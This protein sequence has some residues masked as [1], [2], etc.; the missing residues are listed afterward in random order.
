M[1]PIESS[2]V[3][4]IGRLAVLGRRLTAHLSAS[5]VLLF[6]AMTMAFPLTGCTTVSGT[7]RTQFNFM[8]REQELSLGAGAYQEELA[9]A[10]LV[11]SGPQFDMVKRVTK[12]VSAAAEKLHPDATKGFTWEFR[13][14]D[15]PDTINAWAL[16]GGKMAVYT[17]L[18]KAAKNEDQLAAV[19][20]HECSHAIGRHGGERM[21]QQTAAQAIM[22]GVGVGLSFSEMSPTAQQATMA[23]FGA[24]SEYGVLLPFSRHQ[25]SEADELGLFIAA[26]A[27]YDP[28]EAVELWKNMG[29]IGGNKPPE[30]ASTHPSDETR[31][32]RLAELM[33]RAM[34][35]WKASKKKSKK[36]S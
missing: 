4:R 1:L 16:P 13:L 27:G 23:A 7:G 12:R 14:I 29:S 22:A 17:G 26:E 31:Q 28:R 34:E 2:C 33:P 19:M 25:E 11:T 18:F 35:I 5:V 30:W 6:M 15:A 8:S 9:D 36:D 21:S 24:G 32:A 3:L 20:G 10:K